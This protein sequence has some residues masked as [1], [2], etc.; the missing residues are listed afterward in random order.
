MR[1][2]LSWD[3]GA[4]MKKKADPYTMNQDHKNN[5]VEKYHTGDPS[6]WAED[7]DMKTPW[8]G[9]GRNEVGLP[10]PER[11]AVMAARKLEDKALK[12]IT[13][14]QRMLPGAGDE[15]IEAQATDLMYMPENVVLATLSRQAELAEALAGKDEDDEKDE[16][17]A[18]KKD[19]EGDEEVEAAKKDD[20]KDEEVEAAKKEDDEDAEVEA[21]KKD[22]EEKEKEAAKAKL[23]YEKAAKKSKKAMYDEAKKDKK[24]DEKDA[25]KKDMD[26]KDEKDAAKKDDEKDEK[27][28]GKKDEEEMDEKDAGK[29]DKEEM[30]EKDAAKKDDEEMDEKDAAKKDDDKD[31]KDAAKKDDEE[32]VDASSIDLLDQIFAAETVKTGAKKLS[33][34]VK[35][36]STDSV[37][38]DSLWSA[39][40]DVSKAFR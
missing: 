17:D 7:P 31:E 1:Q 14:A 22:M 16:K 32:E 3:K 6:T 33:G 39:P 28:A 10:A 40:P 35:Q 12:C 34:I 5:P 20:E 30:D 18:A 38:L 36:A 4:E 24:D 2:R 29:K 27:D 11:A 15:I 25:A 23:A 13:I 21:A 26:D 9:E 37:S 8:K 19:D